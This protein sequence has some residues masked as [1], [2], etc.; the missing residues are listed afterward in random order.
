MKYNKVLFLIFSFII[1]IINDFSFAD[2]EYFGGI[3]GDLTMKQGVYYYQEV[4]FVDKTPVIMNGTIT[5][6]EIKDPDKSNYSVSVKYE[7]SNELKQANLSRTVTYNITNEYNE[8]TNQNIKTIVIPIGGI[9]EEIKVGADKY[10]LISFQFSNANIV[11]QNPAIN[12]RS[13]NIYYKKVFAVNGNEKNAKNKLIITGESENFLGFKNK[14]SSIETIILKQKIENIEVSTG[15]VVWDGLVKLN[16]SNRYFTTFN[17]VNNDVQNISFRGGLLQS[18]NTDNYLHFEYDMPGEKDLRNI[19]ENNLN[20]YRFEESK[21]LLVPKFVDVNDH[22]ARESIFKLSSLESFPANT[23]FYPDIFITRE[24]FAQAIINAIDYVAA[25]SSDEIKKELI[26]LK[27][28]NAKALRFSDIRRDSP[29]YPYIIKANDLKIMN[30]EGNGQFLPSRP[31]TRAEAIS[32]VI[33]TLGLDDIAP[34]YDYYTNFEDDKKIPLWAKNSIY[35]G[36]KTNIISGYPDNTIRPL[37]LVTKAETAVILDKL[38]NHLNKEIT[39][40]YKEKLLN[41]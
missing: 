40:D 30:G 6:P 23:A 12:F 27:R 26:K 10:S 32:I 19:G 16:F 21:R 8:K 24:E 38:I 33:R 41:N 4:C 3:I 7:L 1:L 11:D 18:K 14:Y 13:G 37:S 29:Y 34:S 17:Y 35:M 39:I 28:P 20:E 5:V 36:I 31:I 25:E 22:W 15:K 9:K 2:F